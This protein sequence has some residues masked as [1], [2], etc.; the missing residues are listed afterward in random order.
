M[1]IDK[2][3]NGYLVKYRTAKPETETNDWDSDYS[4]H[5]YAFLTWEGVVEF[6]KNSEGFVEK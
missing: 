1:N 6:I 3:D 4:R 5:S 2:I